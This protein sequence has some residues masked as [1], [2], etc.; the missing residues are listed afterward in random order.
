MQKKIVIPFLSI[1]VFLWL[2]VV[3]SAE[4]KV[5]EVDANNLMVREQPARN[6]DIIGRLHKGD[7]VKVFD[8]KYGWFQTYVNGE[9]GWVASHYLFP[10][11]REVKQE[12]VQKEVT[13]NGTGVRVRTGPST[14]HKIQD[15]TTL[16]ATLTVLDRSEDWLKVNYDNGNTGWVAAWLTSEGKTDQ[17][18]DPPPQNE[19]AVEPV[20]SSAKANDLNGINVVLDPGHG[21][22]DPGA[23]GL[24]GVYEKKL[25]LSM[26]K[27]IASEL[28][29]AG[30]TAILTRSSDRYL[31]LPERLHISSAYHTDVF[32]SVHFNAH[33]FSAVNGISTYYYSP[34]NRQLAFNMQASLADH[35]SLHN[36]GVMHDGF[37]VLRNNADKALLLELGFLTNSHDLQTIQ[38]SDYANNVSKAIRSALVNH[39]NE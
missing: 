5:Y 25:T 29:S 15:Y 36:R 33:P 28:E 30:A 13:V 31:S 6:A 34:E 26:A 27:R 8:E 32:L 3:I 38:T 2:P 23:I 22:R 7:Q 16:G 1:L 12:S 17:K 10:A 21:G 18:A 14:N 11:K 24:N 20:S 35:T 19:T 37:Y 39:L 9:A 4:E